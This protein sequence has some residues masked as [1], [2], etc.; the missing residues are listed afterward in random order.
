MGAPL[1]HGRRRAFLAEVYGQEAQ[2]AGRIA[3]ELF[4]QAFPGRLQELL[5]LGLARKPAAA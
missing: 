5:I 4:D 2:V 3:R 1:V